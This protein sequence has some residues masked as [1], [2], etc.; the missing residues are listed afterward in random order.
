MQ[1]FKQPDGKK[2]FTTGL[3]NHMMYD[4]PCKYNF[5]CV[6]MYLYIDYETSICGQASRLNHGLIGNLFIEG[7]RRKNWS[8]TTF[9]KGGG[10]EKS[11]WCNIIQRP[12][13]VALCEQQKYC[14]HMIISYR[15]RCSVGSGYRGLMRQEDSKCFRIIQRFTVSD[16]N[17]VYRKEL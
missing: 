15:S 2:A 5:F 17:L 1:S 13:S 6:L 9:T 3:Y 12:Q 8:Q 16:N 4:S 10:A 11:H 14:G 7:Q